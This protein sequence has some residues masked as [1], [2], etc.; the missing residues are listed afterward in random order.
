MLSFVKDYRERHFFPSKFQQAL[1]QLPGSFS[2]GFEEIFGSLVR[3]FPV[4]SL[5]R[6]AGGGLLAPQRLLFHSM[7]LAVCPQLLR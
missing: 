7:N 3:Y 5:T 1:L 6:T 2:G 4:N